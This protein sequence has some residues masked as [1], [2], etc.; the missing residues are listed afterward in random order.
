MRLIGNVCKHSD[1]FS[2]V[3]LIGRG[4]DH[5]FG[6]SSTSSPTQ[7]TP[8]FVRFLGYDTKKQTAFLK[9]R[10]FFIQSV[11]N[12]HILLCLCYDILRMK[13]NTNKLMGV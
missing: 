13:K 5:M 12:L 4:L 10:S 6:L 1:M 11:K 3:V 2:L 7:F 9:G 8:Y